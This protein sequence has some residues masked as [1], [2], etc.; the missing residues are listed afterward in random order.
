MSQQLLETIISPCIQIGTYT[1]D[2]QTIRNKISIFGITVLSATVSLYSG[3][4]RIQGNTDSICFT[5]VHLR[6][7]QE[8]EEPR[9]T[10]M[11]ENIREITGRNRQEI[12]NKEHRAWC[13]ERTERNSQTGLHSDCGYT[14]AEIQEQ[15]TKS[16]QMR[17]KQCTDLISA[18]S[19]QIALNFL[20]QKCN[21]LFK[22]SMAS[23]WFRF[24]W[25]FGRAH[26]KIK[27]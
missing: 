3:V 5:C 27:V 16:W 22:L 25:S 17:R 9:S 21:F 4:Y 26:Y 2:I 18:L 19:F 1:E 11:G 10:V 6:R 23:F 24:F 7:L 20:K 15:P 12:H 13:P 14:A 8:E